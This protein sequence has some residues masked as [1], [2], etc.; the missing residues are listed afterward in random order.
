MAP[1]NFRE[2]LASALAAP[3]PAAPT[4]TDVPANNEPGAIASEPFD[5]TAGESTDLSALTD[6]AQ[7]PGAGGWPDDALQAVPKLDTG[8]ARVRPTEPV[9]RARLWIAE[10][11]TFA[12]GDAPRVC[13][14]SGIDA[15]SIIAVTVLGHTDNFLIGPDSN[16]A[17]VGFLLR[18]HQPVRI[19]TGPV[20]AVGPAAG[21]QLAVATEYWSDPD[22]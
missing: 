10:T 9:P 16:S 15:R 18:L 6:W 13:T 8:P 21:G 20:W 1:M 11:L 7:T 14:P 4:Y 22:E 19:E 3:Q 17:R 5:P 12:V 2:R